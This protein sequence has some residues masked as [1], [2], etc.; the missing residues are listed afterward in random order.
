[1]DSINPFKTP[2]CMQYALCGS[3]AYNDRYPPLILP[4]IYSGQDHADK[5]EADNDKPAEVHNETK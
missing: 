4:P 3:L 5:K 1:M 2:Y